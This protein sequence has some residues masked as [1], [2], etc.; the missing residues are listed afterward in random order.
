MNFVQKYFLYKKI[1]GR[2]PNMV[3][4]ND[5]VLSGLYIRDWMIDNIKCRSIYDREKGYTAV[6]HL[7]DSKCVVFDGARALK[8]Y[9]HVS[10]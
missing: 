1:I 3:K 2:S 6:I 8:I 5:Y 10:R 7:P 9:R 4:M